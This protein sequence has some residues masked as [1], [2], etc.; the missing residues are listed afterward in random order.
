[1]VHMRNDGHYP[2]TQVLIQPNI[3]L[4]SDVRHSV[5]EI[6]NNVLA[7]EAVLTQKTRCACWNIHG[8]GFYD[9]H[10]LLDIQYKQLNAISDELSKR[11]RVLGSMPIGSFQ[12]FLFTTRLVELPGGTPEIMDLLADHEASIRL[13]REYA[14]NAPRSTR[15]KVRS[16]Y[17]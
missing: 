11:I 4:D 6:L 13:L 16:N 14:K 17:W 15:T 5:V 2:K 7:D 12:E 10:T 8:E 3:G 1:M 9:R